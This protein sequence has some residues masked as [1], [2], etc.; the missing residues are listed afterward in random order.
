MKGLV[1]WQRWEGI[2]L[3]SEICSV[4]SSVS[5]LLGC[6]AKSIPTPVPLLK[7]GSRLGSADITP[8]WIV[9]GLVP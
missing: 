4:S 7:L 9:L 3:A 8:G 1:A 5:K 2:E 6:P